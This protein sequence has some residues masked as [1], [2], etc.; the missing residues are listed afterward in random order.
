[1]NCKKAAQL[2]PLFVK[3]DLEIDEM[4]PIMKHLEACDSCRCVAKEFQASQSLLH[5]F[6]LPE[7]DEADFFQIRSAVLEKIARPRISD[8]ITPVL[9]W[10]TAFAASFA[11]IVLS[12]G[13]VIYQRIPA[14]NIV[15]K[16]PEF[17]EAIDQNTNFIFPVSAKFKRRPVTRQQIP[18][19]RSGRNSIAQGE[20]SA[21]ERNPGK[22][23]EYQTSPERAIATDNAFNEKSVAANAANK[24]STNV[25]RADALGYMLTPAPQ[26]GNVAENLPEPEMLRMEIQTADPNIKII[27]LMPQ[28]PTNTQADHK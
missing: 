19:P 17:S 21:R 2:I 13:I 1:M 27:W 8:L 3:A 15:V 7:F 16:V 10:K 23:S 28:E 20:A 18:K 6:A 22:D 11:M 12:S 4:Q 14:E 24:F 5:S 26:A 9:N 25:P